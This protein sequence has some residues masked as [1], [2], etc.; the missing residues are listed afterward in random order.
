MMEES[1]IGVGILSG[2]LTGC[3][4]GLPPEYAIVHRLSEFCVRSAL[5]HSCI[6]GCL[7]RIIP[8][9]T[10]CR[11]VPEALPFQDRIRIA[12]TT[13]LCRQLRLMNH[14][15]M[16]QLRLWRPKLVSI[17]YAPLLD[18]WR[19]PQWLPREF[20]FR[21][22]GDRVDLLLRHRHWL[23]VHWDSELLCCF[24]RCLLAPVAIPSRIPIDCAVGRLSC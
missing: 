16:N 3:I 18:P 8:T 12:C 7:I 20:C 15:P 17:R 4:A 10:S 21:V 1:T 6:S 24:P 11:T 14:S 5:T 9:R 22:P 19:H 13:R 23:G 2:C